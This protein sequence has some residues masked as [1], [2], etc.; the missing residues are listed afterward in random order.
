MEEIGERGETSLETTALDKVVLVSAWVDL[1]RSPDQIEEAG[2]RSCDA[3]PPRSPYKFSGQTCWDLDVE[4]SA[5][6]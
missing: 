3:F 5:S 6:C 1:P 4:R 2:A